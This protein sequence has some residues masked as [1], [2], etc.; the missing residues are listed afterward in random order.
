MLPTLVRVAS[1]VSPA[2]L[3]PLPCALCAQEDEILQ[4]LLFSCP[5]SRLIWLSSRWSLDSQRFAA[6][7]VVLWIKAILSP[8]RSL[9]IP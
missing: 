7:L 3:A 6:F 2:V 1:V 5:F 8:T 4:H 9:G